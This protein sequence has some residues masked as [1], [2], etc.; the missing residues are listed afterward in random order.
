M[1]KSFRTPAE[2][3]RWFAKHHETHEELI[4]VYYRVDSGKP[5]V[6][7]PQSVDEALCVGWIDGIRRSEDSERY[8]VRFTPRRPKSVWSA[9]NVRRVAELQA[10]GRM[11]AAGLAVFK[12]RGEKHAVGYTYQRRDATLSPE[13]LARIK[14][15][16][17]AWTFLEARAPSYKRL[18]AYWVMSAKQEATRDRRLERLIAACAAG[19][20]L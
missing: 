2:L 12:A 9:I 13:F 20:I 3:R 5:S 11:Q 7:W 14:K 10:E 6:T 19:K 17:A 16:K 8:S 15:N 18:M 4:L 1:K